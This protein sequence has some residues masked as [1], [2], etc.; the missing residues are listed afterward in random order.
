MYN[1]SFMAF[2]ASLLKIK[3]FFEN[4]RETVPLQQSDLFNRFW[5]IVV[6]IF[7]IDEQGNIITI[8]GNDEQRTVF[9]FEQLIG[10]VLL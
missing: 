1:G 10:A 3:I 8:F 6:Y 4:R 7:Q 5:P 2:F 9:P